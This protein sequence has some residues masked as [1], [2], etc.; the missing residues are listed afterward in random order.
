MKNASFT[1]TST[2][3]HAVV[4]LVLLVVLGASLL[5]YFNRT[6]GWFADNR[7]VS[8]SG[9]EVTLAQ[10]GIE[11]TYFAKGANETEFSPILPRG[12]V[13]SGIA[14][15]QRISLQ[16]RYVNNSAENRALSVYLGLL[17][18]EVETPLVLDGKYYYLSTQ[19]KI[20][21]I[22]VN[23]EFRKFA[24][25]ENGAEAISQIQ[26]FIDKYLKDKPQIELDFVHGIDHLKETAARYEGVGVVMPKFPKEELFRFVLEK[27]ILPRKA[28]SMGEAEE[29]RYYIL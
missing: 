9:A 21:E 13:F 26:Q 17:A 18:N 24:A 20:V 15:V 4:I 5:V 3:K 25:P 7:N 23:G 8:A 19:L 12:F 14:P 2:L 11:G 16:A 1:N 28:F 27:G 6:L 10:Y 22:F 29:K